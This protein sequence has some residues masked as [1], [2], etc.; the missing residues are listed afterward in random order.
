MHD[1]HFTPFSERIG[2][3]EESCYEEEAKEGDQ[4][5]TRQEE[6]VG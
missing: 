5:E 2:N 4:E 1:I 3:G 6:E